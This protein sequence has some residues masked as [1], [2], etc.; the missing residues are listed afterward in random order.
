M[1]VIHPD[2]LDEAG[3]LTPAPEGAIDPRTG[4]WARSGLDHFVRGVVHT[5]GAVGLIYLRLDPV[6]SLRA[7]RRRAAANALLRI[8]ALRIRATVRACEALGRVGPTSLVVVLHSAAPK[9]GLMVAER[10][11]VLLGKDPIR[12]SPEEA[13]V[14]VSVGLAGG[15]PRTDVQIDELFEAAAQAALRATALGG[16]QVVQAPPRMR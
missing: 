7:E 15:A 10:I 12:L 2:W 9:V 13:P 6:D 8:A 4:L 3:E 1:H 5:E 11:R 16:D 14:T